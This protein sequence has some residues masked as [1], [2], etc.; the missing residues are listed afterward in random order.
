[1]TNAV[2]S[3]RTA[4]TAVV[5]PILLAS[6]MYGC[7]IFDLKNPAAPSGDGAG[8]PFYIVDI[9]KAADPNVMTDMGYA[10]YFTNDVE[11]LDYRLF[12]ISGRRVTQMLERLRS[13]SPQSLRVDW[14]FDEVNKWP[15]P[16]G[17]LYHLNNVRYTVYTDGAPQYGGSADF[18]ILMESNSKISYWKDIP[19]GDPFFFEP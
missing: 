16:D 10:D 19:D 5:C 6:V 11:F 8:D 18:R 1:M 4:A 13:R 3:L 15:D 17:K 7:S 14:R 12:P 2:R 9:L